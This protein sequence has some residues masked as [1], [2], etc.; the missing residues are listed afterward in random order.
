MIDIATALLPW[1]LGVCASTTVEG[2]RMI[3]L[4][5]GCVVYGALFYLGTRLP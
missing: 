1:V 4:V 3:G 5:V 2:H